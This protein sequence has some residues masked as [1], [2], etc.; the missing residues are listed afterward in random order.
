MCAAR[1]DPDGGSGVS[2]GDGVGDAG[3]GGEGAGDERE[4]EGRRPN[5]STKKRMGL[6]PCSWPSGDPGGESWASLNALNR[7]EKCR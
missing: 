3:E 2:V 5:H 6:A 1:A 7:L 4:G